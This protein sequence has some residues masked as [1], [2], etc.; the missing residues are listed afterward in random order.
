M[1]NLDKLIA[2]GKSLGL[3]GDK[4]LQFMHEREERE[5]REK[6][7]AIAREERLRDREQKKIEQLKLEMLNKEIE[8]QKAKA[9]TTPPP[10]ACP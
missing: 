7:D 2:A 1:E 4:L 6:L 3:E 8:L 10:R 9:E 5:Q